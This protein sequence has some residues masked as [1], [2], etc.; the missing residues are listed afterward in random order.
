MTLTTPELVAVGYAFLFV[1][2]LGTALL[3]YWP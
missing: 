1:L 3:R 2:A